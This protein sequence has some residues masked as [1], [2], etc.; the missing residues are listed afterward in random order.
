MATVVVPFR[1][2]D[3]KRRL[4]GLNAAGRSFLAHAMLADV[5]AAAV[6]VGPV[7][8]AAQGE[9]ELPVAV[10]RVPD[11][12][13]GQGAAVQAALDAAG[14]AGRSGPVL[15]V[16]ADLPC[17][18]TRDLLALAG[19]MPGGG[20]AIAAA[21]DG[22]TNALALADGALFEPVYGAGSALRFGVLAPSRLLDV[23]N[24]VDD[25]DTLDDLIRL[26]DRLGSSTRRAL[27][28]LDLPSA[29]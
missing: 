4:D 21:P 14:A 22:T 20:I 17:A 26:R 2:H 12:G 6:P 23:P 11:P 25:V 19:A 10:T 8:V 18:D 3:P 13:R 5:L 29:A 15:V 1:S 28:A 7:L 9:V 16:N 24:L 27:A